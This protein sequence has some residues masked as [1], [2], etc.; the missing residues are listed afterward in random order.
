MTSYL[1]DGGTYQ[2][3]DWF[4][5]VIDLLD[6][7]RWVGTDGRKVP[8]STSFEFHQGEQDVL[9]VACEVLK[10]VK[11]LPLSL[12]IPGAGLLQ[13]GIYARVRLQPAREKAR[14]SPHRFMELAR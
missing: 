13:N 14:D 6:T 7:V 9:L 1:T 5:G 8:V 10:L 11:K 3:L 2:S 12:D 4:K